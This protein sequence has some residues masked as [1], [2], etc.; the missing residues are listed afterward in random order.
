ML[1][2]MKQRLRAC[3]Q[4]CQSSDEVDEPKDA[5]GAPVQ[6][7]TQPSSLT[8]GPQDHWPQAMGTGPPQSMA[9]PVGL[10]GKSEVEWSCRMQLESRLRQRRCQGGTED[11]THVR[12]GITCSLKGLELW[13]GQHLALKPRSNLW[14]RPGGRQWTEHR[15]PGFAQL[16]WLL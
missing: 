1:F 14:P 4:S 12:P 13:Q 6:A 11:R 3:A 5:K 10:W 2:W 9:T 15:K 7:W 16:A 8:P